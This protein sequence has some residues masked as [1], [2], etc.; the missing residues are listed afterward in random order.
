MLLQVGKPSKPMQILR[1]IFI[2]FLSFILVSTSFADRL[3]IEPDA[4][5]EPLVTEI[6]KA[7]SSVDL[8]MYGFT[9]GTLLN[10]LI[11]AKKSGK[12]V[13]VLLEPS[14]YKAAGENAFAIKRLQSANINLQW[15]SDEFKLTHQKTFLIDKRSAIIMTFN[16]THSTFKNERNFALIIDN[17]AMVNE[18]NQVFIADW[19]HRHITVSNPNL[20]WSPDNS[21]K[22]I[23][24][25]IRSANASIKM[26]AQDLSDYQM[27]GALANA[28]REGKTVEILMME[29][30]NKK[31]K[32]LA[33]LRKAGA[34]IHFSKNY[35]IHAKVIIID[36]K[37]AMLGS[38]NLTKASI[39][40]NR[41]L[42]VITKDPRVVTTLSHTFEQDYLHDS[43]K[44]L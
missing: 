5:R 16:L 38:I 41:E 26:Y 27:I 35:I 13:Q 33:Y 29:P 18:I 39:N 42:S 11:E 40:N 14:P 22:K 4:G 6:K 17:P 15:P 44:I 30:K 9:D 3:I 20:I 25:F 24:A 10:A 34:T 37:Q 8:V 23:I 12:N 2:F 36:Q 31:N 28:A 1:F 43:P 21:R 7:K 19:Q 32:K